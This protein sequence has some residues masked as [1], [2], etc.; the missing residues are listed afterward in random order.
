MHSFTY[1][2]GWVMK[3]WTLI[4]INERLTSLCK[5][6]M[7]DAYVEHNAFH[8]VIKHLSNLSHMST[9]IFNV[10]QL[11]R[12][13]RSQVGFPSFFSHNQWRIKQQK[14]RSAF[15]SLYIRQPQKGTSRLEI[16]KSNLWIKWSKET[17]TEMLGQALWTAFKTNLINYHCWK[18]YHLCVMLLTFWVKQCWW[19]S[20]QTLFCLN[21]NTPPQEG[22]HKPQ[23]QKNRT[24]I[25][26]CTHR[27]PQG[28]LFLSITHWISLFPRSVAHMSHTK[29]PITTH[30]SKHM[31]TS[32]TKWKHMIFGDL[33]ERQS[34]PYFHRVL[35]LSV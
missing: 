14:T 20:H 8:I 18:I 25:S 24:F 7:V 33:N 11:K 31:T 10:L 27:G 15:V 4:Y 19:C 23:H 6:C 2:F 30:M 34:F 12:E 28:L 1:Q 16:K 9:L 13:K 3:S 26:Y 5:G 21:R 17:K 35:V 22:C 32:E 29:I